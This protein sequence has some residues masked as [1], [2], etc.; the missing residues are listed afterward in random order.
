MKKNRFLRLLPVS[1]LIIILISLTSLGIFAEGGAAVTE[2]EIGILTV[3]LIVHDYGI[4]D[5]LLNDD[6]LVY[7][8]INDSNTVTNG[9]SIDP[10]KNLE[11]RITNYAKDGHD[12]RISVNVYCSNVY[13]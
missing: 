2:P 11:I 8:I 9:M 4:T 3:P 7:E 6:L 12:F 5:D 13:L 1:L 10:T